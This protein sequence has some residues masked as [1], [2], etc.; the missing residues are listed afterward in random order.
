[1]T[2]DEEGVAIEKGGDAKPSP[3]HFVTPLPHHLASESALSISAFEPFTEL[4]KS[5]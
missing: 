5:S 4:P 1:M 3:R 2:N